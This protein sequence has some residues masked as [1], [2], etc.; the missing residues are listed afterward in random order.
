[1]AKET[2]IQVT[3]TRD[4]ENMRFAETIGI[5]HTQKEKFTIWISK[6]RSTRKYVIQNRHLDEGDRRS[7][8]KQGERQGDENK[9][10][11][12]ESL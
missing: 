1:M 5:K 7:K 10:G 6:T 4:K 12:Y 2:N 9:H 11:K 3:M 8:I